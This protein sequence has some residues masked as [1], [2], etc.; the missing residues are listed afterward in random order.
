MK[1]HPRK[2]RSVPSANALSRIGAC[3]RTKNLKTFWMF[4]NHLEMSRP[5]AHRYRPI[6][7]YLTPLQPKKSYW[8]KDS[9]SSMK[10]PKMIPM[11]FQKIQKFQ[12]KFRNLKK[13]WKLRKLSCLLTKNRK[14]LMKIKNGKLRNL[15]WTNLKKSSNFSLCKN[16]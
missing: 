11:Q 5:Y 4:S 14:K 8:N 7:Q 6:S 3:A 15:R 2:W 9:K 1:K 12:L 16:L 13:M 10:I